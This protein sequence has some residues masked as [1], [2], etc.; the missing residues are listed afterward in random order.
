MYT[1]TENIIITTEISKEILRNML[2]ANYSLHRSYHSYS[3]LH[4][5]PENGQL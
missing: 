3:H 5:F 4:N 2:N 1:Y